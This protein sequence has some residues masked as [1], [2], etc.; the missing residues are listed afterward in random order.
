MDEGALK[1]IYERAFCCDKSMEVVDFLYRNE[2]FTYEDFMKNVGTDVERTN[3]I[4]FNLTK[5]R[6]IEPYKNDS[7]DNPAAVEFNLDG[8]P[9][10]NYRWFMMGNVVDNYRVDDFK[11]IHE[12]TLNSLR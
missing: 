7:D 4:L 5:W 2:E 11:H 3:R 1:I 12:K 9:P 8:A 6:L 10:K